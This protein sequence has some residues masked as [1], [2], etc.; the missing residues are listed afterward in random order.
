ML[1]IN[2]KYCRLV[3]SDNDEK[4]IGKRN[5]SSPRKSIS[6]QRDVNMIYSGLKCFFKSRARNNEKCSILGRYFKRKHSPASKNITR[7]RIETNNVSS[8]SK[9]KHAEKFNT[10]SS[11]N[12]GEVSTNQDRSQKYP[13]IVKLR[14][15]TFKG[16]GG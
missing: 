14:D 11:D 12:I 1:S 6:Q 10:R 8:E 7:R 5:P 13:F 4:I 3:H 15:G 9:C 2:D 16:D